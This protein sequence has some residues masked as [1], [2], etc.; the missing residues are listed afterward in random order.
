MSFE[1]NLKM[2]SIILV[3]N[4]VFFS[5]FGFGM[6]SLYKKNKVNLLKIFLV[7]Y[8]IFLTISFILHNSI[9]IYLIIENVL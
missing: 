4:M 8:Y 7:F 3:L 6:Y 5:V 9:M 1:N 2:G